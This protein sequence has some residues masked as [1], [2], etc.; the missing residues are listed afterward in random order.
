[1]EQGELLWDAGRTGGR[2][3]LLEIRDDDHDW[4]RAGKGRCASSPISLR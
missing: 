1:M 3:R 4:Y 2:A